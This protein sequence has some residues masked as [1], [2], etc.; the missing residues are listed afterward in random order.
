ML[1]K[2]QSLIPTS[3]HTGTIVVPSADQW[4]KGYGFESLWRCGIIV[5]VV[6]NILDFLVKT[7][8]LQNFNA[9]L[10]KG[11]LFVPG[12]NRCV[13]L[14]DLR[15]TWLPPVGIVW[16]SF[17]VSQEWTWVTYF[18]NVLSNK[19]ILFDILDFW[20]QLVVIRFVK[21]LS[22]R[23]MFV[24]FMKSSACWLLHRLI[25]ICW[26]KRP[27]KPRP[28]LRTSFCRRDLK[29]TQPH[30]KIERHR[31]LLIGTKI[32]MHV[33][34]EKIGRCSGTEIIMRKP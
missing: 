7:S 21:T 29:N 31:I 8:Y 28:N 30:L 6:K 20:C 5:Q 13:D 19:T 2:F 10:P 9:N 4:Y 11:I 24:S 14:R 23:R 27:A 32:W 33:E 15:S 25:K 26:E 17:S 12:G 3:Q 34:I 1:T 18:I 16:H 22:K